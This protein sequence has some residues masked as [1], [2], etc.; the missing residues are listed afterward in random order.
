MNSSTFPIISPFSWHSEIGYSISLYWQLSIIV[1]V[2]NAFIKKFH[3]KYLV[4]V[5]DHVCFRT[6]EK[7]IHLTNPIN[8]LIKNSFLFT[9]E[10]RSWY[11]VFQ[12]KEFYLWLATALKYFVIWSF[13]YILAYNK[14]KVKK[15]VEYIFWKSKNCLAP[16]TPS[17]PKFYAP[18]FW[19][20]PHLFSHF[21]NFL[22]PRQKILLWARAW[23]KWCINLF[24]LFKN[25]KFINVFKLDWEVREF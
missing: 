7:I 9:V 23:S 5:E 10:C 3:P 1:F 8:L 20:P 19:C 6:K 14:V 22:F 18:P 2:F 25:F 13:I 4:L 24:N 16:N 17:L 12:C 11:L 15:Y 21:G